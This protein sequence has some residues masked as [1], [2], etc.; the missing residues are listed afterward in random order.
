[1]LEPLLNIFAVGFRVSRNDIH[2]ENNNIHKFLPPFVLLSIRN[3]PSFVQ[4]N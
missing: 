3:W 1:L 2:L 4:G